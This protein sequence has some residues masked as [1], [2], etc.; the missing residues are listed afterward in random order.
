MN[1][2]TQNSKSVDCRQMTKS[3]RIM[4]NKGLFGAGINLSV[5]QN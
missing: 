5:E 2:K 1:E 4:G 3:E